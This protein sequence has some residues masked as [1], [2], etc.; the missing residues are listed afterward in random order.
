MKI[1]IVEDSKKIQ[2]ILKEEL[3]HIEGVQLCGTALNPQDA[4]R[5]ILEK[6]PDLVIL[7]IV[8]H[9]GN[10]F[11]V[12]EKIKKEGSDAKVMILTNHPF[13]HYRLKS[14]EL[15]AELFFDKSIELENAIQAIREMAAGCENY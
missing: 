6:G 4:I 3:D 1:F 12:L 2:E 15:G 10:G 11:E 5:L 7:D 13:L 14:M 9:N 8:L